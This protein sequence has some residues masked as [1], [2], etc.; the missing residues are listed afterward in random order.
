VIFM[1]GYTV[2]VVSYR[3]FRSPD[4]AF[5]QK[6]FTSEA[7]ERKVREVLDR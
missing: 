2:D 7:L 1:S 3:G 5:L 6:P 4:F